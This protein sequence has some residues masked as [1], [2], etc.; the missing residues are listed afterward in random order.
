MNLFEGFLILLA[1]MF[2]WVAVVV[3]VILMVI[4]SD[5]L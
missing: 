4:F 2:G 5:D 3:V 1:L